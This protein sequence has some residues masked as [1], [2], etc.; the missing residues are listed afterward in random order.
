[1]TNGDK[2]RSMTDDE[3]ANQI[4]KIDQSEYIKFCLNKPECVEGDIDITNDMCKQCL[5]EYLQKEVE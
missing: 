1:M 2:I 3:L 5:M 4:L